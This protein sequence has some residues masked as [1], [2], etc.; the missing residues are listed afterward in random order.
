[1]ARP[2]KK[3]INYYPKDVD[4]YDDFRIVDLMYEHGTLGQTVY[5]V[6]LTIIYR[7]GYYVEI[8]IEKMVQ[9]VIR[10]IGNKWAD[11]ES[12]TSAI[13]YCAEIGLL[14]KSLLLRGVFTSVGI[15]RRYNEIN[16]RNKIDKSAYW[17]LNFGAKTAVSDSETQVIAAKTNVSATKTHVSAQE[18][19]QNKIKENKR[20]VNNTLCAPA[21]HGVKKPDYESIVSLFNSICAGLPSVRSITDARK[22]AIRNA[23]KRVEEYGGWEKLFKTVQH[24][25]FLTGRN[26]AWTNCG[27]D[28]IL[29]PGNLTK[30]IEGNYRNADEA[31]DHPPASYD[32]EEMERRLLHGD[33][34]YKKNE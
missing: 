28:W 31:S 8:P 20:K 22:R 14:D 26:G 17:L 12:V 23:E 30:I 33:I 7:N 1:M 18:M 34:V 27:F 16:A 15:Q 32:I 25:D 21:A 10:T 19:R 29:K 13:L 24:S 5:D 6:I 3:G 2:P 9:L 4:Y 11:K